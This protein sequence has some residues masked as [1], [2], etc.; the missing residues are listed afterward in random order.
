MSTVLSRDPFSYRNTWF[1][2]KVKN[3]TNKGTVKHSKNGSPNKRKSFT[4]SA[5]YACIPNLKNNS[6]YLRESTFSG[7]FLNSQCLTK[8][9]LNN[10]FLF[11]DSAENYP[12]D[13]VYGENCE[14]LHNYTQAK[15]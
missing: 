12:F 9:S 3:T 5:T 11:P 15:F 1:V 8:E 7:A 4:D 10:K 13:H 14:Y 6:I 2:A